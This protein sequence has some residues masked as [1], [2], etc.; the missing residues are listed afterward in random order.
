VP[1]SGTTTRLFGADDAEDEEEDRPVNVYADPKYPDFEFL[2]HDNPEYSVDQG[3]EVFLV[4][5]EVEEMQEDCSRHNDKYQFATY[6][7]KMLQ[8]GE[9]SFNGEWTTYH[10]TTTFF[11]GCQFLSMV[12]LWRQS[13]I[14]LILQNNC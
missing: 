5:E 11:P 8:N 10:S 7:A 4:E 12:G 3:E 6:H 2:N 1:S 9:R 13:L 14:I